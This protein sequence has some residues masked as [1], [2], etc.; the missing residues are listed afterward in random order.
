[1]STVFHIQYSR[2]LKLT[3]RSSIVHCAC[4]FLSRTKQGNKHFD[5]DI[6]FLGCATQDAWLAGP[7]PSLDEI[8]SE[9]G[10]QANGNGN[11]PVYEVYTTPLIFLFLTVPSSSVFSIL[12][13]KVDGSS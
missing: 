12:I 9:V 6:F 3:C 1:M 8:L 7:D 2:M 11:T 4:V 5:I 13:G 10:R